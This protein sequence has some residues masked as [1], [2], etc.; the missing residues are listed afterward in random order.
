MCFS[1][2]TFSFQDYHFNRY[3]ISP[4]YAGFTGSAKGI[5]SY[6]KAWI[7]FPGSPQDVSLNIDASILKNMGLGFA[8][9]N[10]ITGIFQNTTITPAYAY[11]LAISKGNLISFGLQ[12]QIYMQTVNASSS[13][14]TTNDPA[15]NLNRNASAVSI[16][17]GFAMVYQYNKLETGLAVANFIMNDLKLNDN[18]HYNLVRQLQLHA[19]YSIDVLQGISFE[20]AAFLIN[21]E[22][23]SWLYNI[24]G[25][26]DFM[27]AIWTGI[28]FH[29]GS[30]WG[31]ILG[32]RPYEHLVLHYSYQY[33]TSSVFRYSSGSHEISLGYILEN[34]KQSGKKKINSLLHGIK[35]NRAANNKPEEQR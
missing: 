35:T 28:S 20:P 4:A 10:E 15:V 24:S 3:S 31:V 25:C 34:K 16:V 2:G 1:Q 8:L 5:V 26:L 27:D 18:V 22:N 14:L 30:N 17:P 21:Q 19:S 6:S 7:G 9:N 13:K 32:G 29:D 33:S 11:R 23:K 12:A